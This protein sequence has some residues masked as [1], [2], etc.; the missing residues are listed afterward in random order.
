MLSHSRNSFLEM[1]THMPG[2]H[3]QGVTQIRW[4]SIRIFVKP[5]D[6]WVPCLPR[7]AAAV[8]GDANG[9]RDIELGVACAG[10]IFIYGHEAGELPVVVD[11]NQHIISIRQICYFLRV[12]EA[13]SLY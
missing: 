4:A 8:H 13:I 12:R 10:I 9:F 11:Y 2:L 5:A 3:R 6:I 1:L 7:R